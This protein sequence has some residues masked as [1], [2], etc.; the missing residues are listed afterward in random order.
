MT[1]QDAMQDKAYAVFHNRYYHGPAH[2][3]ITAM[4]MADIEDTVDDKEQLRF[5]FLGGEDEQRD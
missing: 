2:L 5:E 1:H 3:N 4:Q